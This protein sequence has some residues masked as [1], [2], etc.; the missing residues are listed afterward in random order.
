MKRT[1]TK[2]GTSNTVAK[3]KQSKKKPRVLS[4]KVSER[5]PANIQGTL[6]PDRSYVTLKYNEDIAIAIPVGGAMA[7]Y[8]FRCNSI[9]DPNQSGTGHQP[10]GHDQ[11]AN[12]YKKYMVVGS[13]ITATFKSFDNTDLTNQTPSAFTVGICTIQDTAGVI[14]SSTEFMENNRTT[15]SNICPQQPYAMVTKRFD[16]LDFFGLD[17]ILDNEKYGADFGA[18]PEQQAYWQLGLYNPT[19]PTTAGRVYVN[20]AIK[21]TL[22]VRERVNVGGS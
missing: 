6:I 16:P 8:L 15:Y 20:I 9:F 4:K 10:L 21:Y 5:L 7:N 12:F 11:Y 3:H 14:T 1:Y 13:T 2:L 17:N 22:A 19:A 18:N